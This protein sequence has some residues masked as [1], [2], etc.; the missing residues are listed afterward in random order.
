MAYQLTRTL[1]NGTEKTYAMPFGTRRKAAQAAFWCLYDNGAAGRKEATSFAA[2]LH[3]TPLGETVTHESG[4]A[5][6][7]ANAP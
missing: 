4:Y 7:I 3:G 2:R 5:F 1:P 6:T